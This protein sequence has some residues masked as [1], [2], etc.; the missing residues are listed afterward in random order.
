M[1][2]HGLWFR[3]LLLPNWLNFW[4]ISSSDPCSALHQPSP[5]TSQFPVSAQTTFSLFLSLSNTHMLTYIIHAY[6][7][8]CLHSHAHTSTYTFTQA[9]HIEKAYPC[10]HN[11]LHQRSQQTERGESY[12]TNMQPLGVEHWSP[13]CIKFLW[14][15]YQQ[16]HHDV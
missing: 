6:P 4:I 15:L 16:G 2:F 9:H 7:Q 1:P 10:V 5:G 14:A 13:L 12:I 8:P 11:I 3:V